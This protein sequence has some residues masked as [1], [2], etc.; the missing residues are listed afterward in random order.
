MPPPS[1]GVRLVHAREGQ[2]GRECSQ[3]AKLGLDVDSQRVKMLAQEAVP[4]EEHFKRDKLEQSIDGVS[5]AHV[6][7]SSRGRGVGLAAIK[8]RAL[9]KGGQLSIEPHPKQRGTEPVLTMPLQALW[10]ELKTASHS[11]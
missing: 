7:T 5:T 8:A 3:A 10:T 4:Q 11:T 1:T 6:V 9:E 2:K